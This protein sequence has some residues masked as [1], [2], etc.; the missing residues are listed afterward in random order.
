MNMYFSYHFFTLCALTLFG[1]AFM[2]FLVWI[3]SIP[4]LQGITSIAVLLLIVAIFV[5]SIASFGKNVKLHQILLDFVLPGIFCMAI[6]GAI[7]WGIG[8]IITNSF[9]FTTTVAATVALGLEGFVAAG[10]GLFTLFTLGIFLSE[11]SVTEHK[12]VIKK[13]LLVLLSF[14]AYFSICVATTYL[15]SIKQFV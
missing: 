11:F 4:E 1:S 6:L 8:N 3:L 12:K 5:I 10:L 2:S 14:L 13:R 9:G 15:L 7:L